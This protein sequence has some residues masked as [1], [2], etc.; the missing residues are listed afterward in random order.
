MQLTGFASKVN[1]ATKVTNICSTIVIFFY[2]QFGFY[3]SY[4]SINMKCFSGESRICVIFPSGF[5]S[6]IRTFPDILI[7][8]RTD[9][10]PYNM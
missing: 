7:S 10:Q 2:K 5:D 9:L 8:I 6:L 4:F 3:E 1:S